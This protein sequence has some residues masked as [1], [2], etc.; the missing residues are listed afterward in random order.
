[1]SAL[2][3]VCR[4]VGVPRWPYKRQYTTNDSPCEEEEEMEME[5]HDAWE[6]EVIDEFE[7]FEEALRHVEGK[8]FKR[9][10]S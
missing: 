5:I 4:R 7:L 3:S 6:E 10:R 9:R 1:M 2:K 8:T